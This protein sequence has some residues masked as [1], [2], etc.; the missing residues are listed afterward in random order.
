VLGLFGSPATTFPVWFSGCAAH[1]KSHEWAFSPSKSFRACP[2]G[3]KSGIGSSPQSPFES[4]QNFLWPTQ[5]KFGS[6]TFERYLNLQAFSEKLCHNW[7]SPISVSG[8]VECLPSIYDMDNLWLILRH[9][10]SFPDSIERIEISA[11]WQLSH[12]C[13][14]LRFARLIFYRK[15]YFYYFCLGRSPTLSDLIDINNA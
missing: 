12:G 11:I 4:C 13:S 5:E 9:A 2:T 10:T 3:W 14:S 1:W 8:Y 15:S 7:L 6:T